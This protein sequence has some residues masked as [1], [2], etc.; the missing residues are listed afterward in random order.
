MPEIPAI[1]QVVA[2]DVWPSAPSSMSFS[3][4]NEMEA[5]PRRWALNAATFSQ[6]WTK[7]GYPRALQ[8]AALEG[9][10]VHLALERITAALLHENCTSLRDGTA[11][12]AL[13]GLGG[14][15][16]VLTGCVNDILSPLLENPR[17]AATLA[18]TRR[19]IVAKIPSLRSRVQKLLSR[20]VFSPGSARPPL[21]TPSPQI[22]SPLTNGSHAEVRINACELSWHGIA[23]LLLLSSEVC[24]IRDFKTGAKKDSHSLQ[25]R[26]YALLWFRDSE[27]NPTARSVTRLIVSY[28]DGDVEIPVPS[29][30]QL[31]LLERELRER[32][33]IAKTAASTIPPNARPGQENC[34]L[35]S[36]RQLCPEYWQWLSTEA[37]LTPIPG[38]QFTDLEVIITGRHGPTTWNGRVTSSQVCPTDT[39][40]L[41][42]VPVPRFEITPRQL[43]R[44]I[45]AHITHIADN[46]VE[47]ESSQIVAT[48]GRSSEVFATTS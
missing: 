5:C 25:L 17:A 48:L 28:D 14:F 34:S 43:L 21:S 16:A 24:E 3:T 32:T 46:S 7:R 8:S 45:N 39:K 31:E 42:H 22:R 6:I 20:I 29:E 41:L 12:I 10:V 2:P 38:G 36:V 40:V 13:R 1:W 27:L 11:V 9:S 47:G 33:Q 4:L 35:C 44:I 37:A 30:M 26:I 23:D 15:T 18:D 19:D